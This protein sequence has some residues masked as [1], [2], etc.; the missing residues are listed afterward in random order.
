MWVQFVKTYAGKEGVFIGGQKYDLPEETIKQLRK[1]LG[2]NQVFNITAP[3]DP[4][5][6]QNTPK[7]KQVRTDK[8]PDLKTK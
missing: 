4:Q 2:P 6:Q 1:K 7:D 5:K 8:N 3:W